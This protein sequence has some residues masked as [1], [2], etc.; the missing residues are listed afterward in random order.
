[1]KANVAVH[2]K[3]EL[4]IAMRDELLSYLELIKIRQKVCPT[5]DRAKPRYDQF[6]LA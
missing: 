4:R 3:Y 5:P 1:M 2:R 6:Q